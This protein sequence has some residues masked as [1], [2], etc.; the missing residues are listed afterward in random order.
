MTARLTTGM[1]LVILLP[2]AA[3]AQQVKPTSLT[4]E[5]I[6]GYTSS[7]QSI[8]FKNTGDTQIPPLSITVTGPFAMP[9]NTCGKGVKPST[10][11]NIYVTYSPVAIET[12]TGSL[13]IDDGD[14]QPITITLTGTGVN[15]I[16]TSFKHVAYDTRTG[17]VNITMYAMGNVIPNGEPVYVTCIDYEGANQ[18]TDT[19]TLSDNRATVPFTGIDD[20]WECGAIYYGDKQFSSSGYG[21]FWINQCQPVDAC[22]DN[23]HP[24]QNVSGKNREIEKENKHEH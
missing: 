7:P 20:D 13:T 9:S 19:G 8:T 10:H 4:F 23:G 17:N 24:N 6:P 5:A 2:Y 12:D 15:S 1:L 18:I 3:W 16:P 22:H 14:G 21:E 11:C